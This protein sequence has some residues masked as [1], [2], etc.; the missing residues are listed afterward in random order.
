MAFKTSETVLDRSAPAT[1]GDRLAVRIRQQV[2]NGKLKIGQALPSERRLADQFGVARETV[3]SALRQLQSE[4]VIQN[5]GYRRRVL[6]VPRNGTG[7]LAGTVGVLTIRRQS[8][9][10][11]TAPGWESFVEVGAM[12]QARQS[13][14]NTLILH[15]ESLQHGGALDELLERPPMGVVVASAAY[16]TAG[17]IELLAQLSEAGLPVVTEGDPIGGES[18]DRVVS[19]HAAGA[20]M[21][22]RFLLQRG[23]RRILYM[24]PGNPANAYWVRHRLEG[25]R[26]AMNEAGLE[27]LPPSMQGPVTSGGDDAQQFEI[28]VMQMLGYLVNY[29]RQH[30]GFDAVM[31]ASDGQVPHVSSAL[32]KL[33]L[34][35]QD[36]VLITGYD[37]F[38]EDMAERQ[39]E[40][41]PPLATA[42]KENMAIGR[43][44]VKLLTSGRQG[45][46]PQVVYVQPRLVQPTG[47]ES[48]PDE[49]S[50]I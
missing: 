21:L 11:H 8:S 4:G 3:R 37:N 24:L 38:W 5:E 25:Y 34:K 31:C 29:Q 20:A 27:P 50:S 13:H 36:D 39:W 43:Q 48:E 47:G 19:D 32:R 6:T 2:V 30:G 23:R 41:T 46:D 14:L 42:D 28:G 9:V 12:E 18:F 16:R 10:S 44:L 7:I 17:V 35:P 49:V 15:V 1:L 22:T 26:T 40:D 33:G 45:G